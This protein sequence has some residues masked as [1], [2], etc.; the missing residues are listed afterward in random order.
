L[1]RLFGLGA[2]GLGALG[3]GALGLGA[4]ACQS[5]SGASDLEIA[6]V[7]QDA[8]VT[9]GGSAG[10]AGSG[11]E[12]GSAGSPINPDAGTGGGTQTCATPDECPGSE[13]DCATRTCTGGAC[14]ISF[15]DDG[16]EV[17]D[18]IVGD[19]H[20]V[21]CDGAGK[22]KQNVADQDVKDDGNECTLDEC[23]AGVEKHP[24]ASAGTD[25]GTG[26]ATQCDGSGK[27]VG[28][29]TKADCAADTPCTTWACTSGVC[30]QTFKGTT[31]PCGSTASC[32]SGTQTNP[33]KC[34]GA[35]A[36]TDFGT[37]PC[38]AYTCGAT[39]CNTSCTSSAQCV[40]GYYCGSG[41]C[42]PKKT[43]GSQCGAGSECLKGHCVDNVC[44]E[45]ACTG[46][47]RACSAAKTDSA[48]GVCAPVTDLS[49]PDNECAAGR[50]CLTASAQQG[51]QPACSGLYTCDCNTPYPG[52]TS[53]DMC[54]DQIGAQCNNCPGSGPQC[55]DTINQPCAPGSVTQGYMGPGW[56]VTTT[57]EATCPSGVKCAVWKCNCAP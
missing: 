15:A 24:F 57:D 12:A 48:N 25:C 55:S 53:F 47:C 17:D 28:C 38:G 2:F 46:T 54:C 34:N 52:D 13:N 31:T 14:G 43:D 26:S 22:T 19:C 6:N 50:V 8:S 23:E 29:I 45:N 39:S 1:S 11:G 7:D 9:T 42:Q 56:G 20:V 35:G 10:T 27:C 32:S 5:L 30:T 49:D 16:V 33:D 18:Q 21:V 4:L 41:T 3:L 40:S 36:C 44:C 51:Q 37:T